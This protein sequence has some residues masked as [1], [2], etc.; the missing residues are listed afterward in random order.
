MTK[1]YVGTRHFSFEC[2][3]LIEKQLELFEGMKQRLMPKAAP[4]EELVFLIF[5]KDESEEALIKY[6]EKNIVKYYWIYEVYK[7]ES[8]D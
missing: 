7:V 3:A 4:N 6:E 1:T 2:S 5:K 8:N